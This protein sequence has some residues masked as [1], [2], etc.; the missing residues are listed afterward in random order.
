MM[1]DELIL[2][3]QDVG[4]VINQIPMAERG[5][6]VDMGADGTPTSH[7]DKVAEQ[8]ILDHIASHDLPLNVLSEE[9][10]FIDRGYDDVL[11]IDPVDG[12]SNAKRNI[13]YF[14]ISLAVGQDDLDGIKIGVV[15]NPCTGDLYHSE[16]GEGAYF[17]GHRLE[18]S[19]NDA[20]KGELMIST[21]FGGRTN[22]RINEIIKDFKKVRAFGCAS[23]D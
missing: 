3:A 17:N 6:V 14:S 22:D 21:H 7:I 1:L 19:K 20:D 16:K 5:K 4:N 10:G 18:L 9:A 23:L 8:I 11:V 15:Y 13:P 2:L 12:T